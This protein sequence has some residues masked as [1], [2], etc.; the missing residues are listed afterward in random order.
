[1]LQHTMP[2]ISAFTFKQDQRQPNTCPNKFSP[3]LKCLIA[4]QVNVN[5]ANRKYTEEQG[6][7]PQSKQIPKRNPRD[8]EI[9]QQIHI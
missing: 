5:I 3:K 1:M 7:N 6:R 4:T 9:Q 8:S 2:K